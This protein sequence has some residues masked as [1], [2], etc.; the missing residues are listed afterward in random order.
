MD[1]FKSA[2]A[3]VSVPLPSSRVTTQLLLEAAVIFPVFLFVV[4]NRISMKIC[5][6]MVL[7]IYSCIIPI[8]CNLPK[9]G[10]HLGTPV[11]LQKY[12]LL[13]IAKNY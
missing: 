10:K 3:T 8:L 5:K 4:I 11:S 9:T 12:N 2:G 7:I 13:G 1:C 6:I